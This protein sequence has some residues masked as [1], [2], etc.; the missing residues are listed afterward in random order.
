MM[1]KDPQRLC[2]CVNLSSLKS[3][4]QRGWVQTAPSN[5]PTQTVVSPLLYRIIQLQSFKRDLRNSGFTS[6]HLNVSKI[7]C[8]ICEEMKDFQN[9]LRLTHSPRSVNSALWVVS[10]GFEVLCFLL[11]RAEQVSTRASLPSR[12]NPVELMKVNNDEASFRNARPFI[13]CG[14]EWL[15]MSPANVA[16]SVDK[17]LTMSSMNMSRGS[18]QPQKT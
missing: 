17:L 1:V 12:Q 15:N 8:E 7:I 9:H 4:T 13:C 16:A 2:R 18:L 5:V 11:S 3:L 6:V 10:D 14:A